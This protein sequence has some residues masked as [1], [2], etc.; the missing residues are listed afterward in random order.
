MR[1][2]P[3]A[4]TS[5]V[6][7]RRGQSGP[8][9]GG[10]PI[11]IGGLRGLGGGGVVLLIVV[12]LLSRFLGGGGGFDPGGLNGL[13]QAG[14]GSSGL[15]NAPDADNKLKDFIVYVFDD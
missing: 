5:D 12:F 4:S 9:L 8:G 10:L 6:E 2:S 7:D 15:Q 11:P 13:P 14:P 1:W 3:G